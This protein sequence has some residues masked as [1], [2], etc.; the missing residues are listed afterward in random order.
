MINEDDISDDWDMKEVGD[1]AEFQNGYS[2]NDDY[3][4]EEG[5]P[6]IRIQNLTG[7]SDEYNYYSGDEVEE[8]YRVENGDLLF[9]WSATLGSFKWN[10]GSAW[11]NQH[12]YRVEPGESINKNYLYYFLDY[13]S[14]RLEKQ[15]VG[16]TLQHVRKSDVT[17]YPIPVPPLDEQ[18]RIV[19]AVEER[20]ERVER[21]EKSVENIDKLTEEYEKSLLSFLTLGQDPD[22]K[23]PVADTP[24]KSQL[25][26]GWNVTQISEVANVNPRISFEEQ[27]DYAYVPMDA[28]SANKK[29]ITRYER[30]DSLYSGLAKFSQ[31]DIVVARI[32]PCF[33][34]GKMAIASDLPDGYGFAVGSTEFVVIR[35]TDINTEYLF[36][37]LK[38]PIVRQWGKHRLLGATGRERIK[39]SQFRDELTVPVPPEEVQSQIV[40]NIK[41]NDFDKIRTSVNTVQNMFREY[42]TSVLATALNGNI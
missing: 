39:I 3:W 26:D 19:E 5:D 22:T 17:T 25:P 29:V 11:L 27:K 38:S 16:G 34:N 8:K 14:D 13:A 15:M 33:E 24:E 32:T 10:G 7:T 41:K 12:I 23:T 42:D 37:Y 1:V 18:K 20:L 21:L 36:S 31:G 30:R 2:F 28:V 9:A 6:I 35:P 4:E 40:Q